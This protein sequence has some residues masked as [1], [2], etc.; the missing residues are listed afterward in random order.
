MSIN[1]PC[2]HRGQAG[3]N[4]NRDWNGV[5]IL[6]W[7]NTIGRSEFHSCK[8][9]QRNSP[10]VKIFLLQ[11]MG[12]MDVISIVSDGFNVYFP[13]AMLAF[14]LATYFSVGSRLL[15]LLGFQQFVGDDEVTADLVEEGRELIK[16]GYS[17]I[18]ALCMLYKCTLILRSIL[19][20]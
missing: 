2:P 4:K 20:V 14:C 3:C 7:S 6:K 5:V 10:K 8:N 13:M 19:S 11:V 18:S 15:S 9:A 16:R 1:L 12:H 17:F